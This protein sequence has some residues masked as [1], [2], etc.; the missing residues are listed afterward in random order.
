MD[1]HLALGLAVGVAVGAALYVLLVPDWFV[2]VGTAAVYAGAAYFALAT[3]ASLLGEWLRFDDRADRLGRAVGL[4]GLSVSP[5]AFASYYGGRSAAF[6]LVVW[7]MGVLAFLLLAA[8]ASE[9]R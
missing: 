4:F 8:K 1:R 2:A 7:F 9:S 5:L 3:D 6:A